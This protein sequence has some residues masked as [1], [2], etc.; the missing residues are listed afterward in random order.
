M[1]I[2]RL[3]LLA[4]LCALASPALAQPDPAADYPNHP[5]RIIV[6]TSAGGGVDTVT[7]IIGAA[8]RIRYLL[9]GVNIVELFVL[10]RVP[11]RS[12]MSRRQ[13]AFSV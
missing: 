9:C 1:L 11:C 7:R 8:Q 6:S 4:A 13:P 2:Q 5:V 12:P 10:C 3:V